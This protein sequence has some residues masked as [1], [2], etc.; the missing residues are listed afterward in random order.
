MSA[1]T[2]LLIA[3]ASLGLAM[4]VAPAAGATSCAKLS[5]GDFGRLGQHVAQQLVGSPA[6]FEA[7]NQRMDAVLGAAAAD[8]MRQLMG[9][10]YAGCTAAGAGTARMMAGAGPMAAGI[11]GPAMMM[12][13][14]LGWMREGSWRHMSPSQWHDMQ[15]SWMGNGAMMRGSGHGW[16]SGVVVAVGFGVL[17]AAILGLLGLTLYRRRDN[18]SGGNPSVA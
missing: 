7:M 17:L 3:G 5:D 14:D 16:D 18:P 13:P 2:V 8:R 1:R 12:A 10:R 6:S 11:G 4:S 9:R 15:R